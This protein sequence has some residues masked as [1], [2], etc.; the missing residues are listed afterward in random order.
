MVEAICQELVLRKGE[1]RGVLQTIYF[2]G[3]T[4]S[5]LTQSEL[6][7]I[8]DT[9]YVNYLV[10]STAEIT[11]EAN[12]DDFFSR[13]KESFM[14]ELKAL[15]V[16]RLSIGIQSF[17]KEDLAL[18][19]RVHSAENGL[20]SVEKAMRTF[21][22]VTI[23]L[24]YGIPNLSSERFLKNIERAMSFGVPHISAY[25]LT[26]EEKTALEVQ[27]RRG[28]VPKID[29]ELAQE[30]FYLLKETLER[31]SYV[32][33]ELSNFGREGYFSRNNTAYW[34]QRPYIGIGPSAHSYDG[35]CRS[36]NVAN[37][38]KYIRALSENVRPFE[39]EELTDI[40]RYNE[41]IMTGLRTK[42]GVSLQQV[43]VLGD[44]F[45]N[46]LLKEKEAF[47]KR[48]LLQEEKG[49]LQVTE[50]GLFLIDAISRDLFYV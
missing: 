31:H 30:H 23:D 45:E 35:N 39:F 27:V 13:G 44:H 14:Q 6:A 34:E 25:A 2:G 21:D 5:I 26:L 19:G 40:D 24:I 9:L 18:L 49:R 43:Q 22:N 42:K 4:P 38:V 3:G 47:I 12:P 15:S 11:L 50:K 48:G 7:K 17:F 16:N 33:Y 41:L 36:W 37:N 46:H 29:D 8:F 10:S 20:L 32:H 28:E 1:A